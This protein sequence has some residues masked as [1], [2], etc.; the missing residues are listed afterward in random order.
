MKVEQPAVVR[1]I[2][3]SI[4]K[5][6]RVSKRGF[7]TLFFGGGICYLEN[8][9]LKRQ[10]APLNDNH[11]LKIRRSPYLFFEEKRVCK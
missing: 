4:P 9:R 10:E 1:V 5:N 2:L 7:I 8:Y 6:K 11:S 3:A